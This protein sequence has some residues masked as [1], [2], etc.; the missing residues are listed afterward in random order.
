MA[1]AYSLQRKQW[2]KAWSEGQSLLRELEVSLC[3]GLHPTDCR[4]N[5]VQVDIK[6]EKEKKKKKNINAYNQI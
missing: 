6:E 3:S 2:Q 5:F 4:V 1:M